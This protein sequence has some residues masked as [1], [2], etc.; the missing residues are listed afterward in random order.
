[1]TNAKS[2]ILHKMQVCLSGSNKTILNRKKQ[3]NLTKKTQILNWPC[4]EIATKTDIGD[5]N[6]YLALRSTPTEQLLR[7]NLVTDLR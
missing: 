2:K 5:A 3:S 6:A 4:E 1:M 7:R